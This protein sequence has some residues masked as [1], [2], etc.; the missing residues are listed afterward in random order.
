MPRRDAVSRSMTSDASRPRSCWSLLTSVNTG[1]ERILL[2]TR[3]AHSLSSRTLS[4]CKV[5]WYCAPLRR[6]PTRSS[7][8]ACMK[9]LAPGTRASLPRTRYDLVHGDLALCE[10]FERDEHTR[11]IDRAAVAAAGEAEDVVHRR[12]LANQR[13]ELLED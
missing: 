4:P 1:S 10:W 7:W 2:R 9:S 11:G 6:P 13:H 12:I 8:K 5:N 3:G